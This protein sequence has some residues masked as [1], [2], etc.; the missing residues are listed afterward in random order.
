M[1]LYEMFMGPLEMVKPWSMSGIHGVKRF[2]DRTW[3]LCTR[4]VVEGTPPE[5]QLR[6][7]HL[8]IQKVTEDTEGLRFNTAISALMILVNELTREACQYAEIH[9]EFMKLLNPYA[10]HIAEE[11]WATRLGGTGS[12][13]MQSWPRF[14]PSMVEDD[15]VTI[16]VQVNGKLRGRLEAAKDLSKEELEAA[17]LQVESVQPHI[18]GKTIRKVMVVPSKLVNV[19]VG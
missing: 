7:L 9:R 17:A 2:L 6:A 10:P 12:L 16:V 19:V 1:R 14:D 15:T 11:I 5:S 8:C 18:E 13:N 3:R 4:E